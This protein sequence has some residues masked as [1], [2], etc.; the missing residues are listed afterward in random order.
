MKHNN[1][2]LKRTRKIYRGWKLFPYYTHHTLHNKVCQ[3]PDSVIMIELIP[4]Q[5]LALNSPSVRHL[6]VVC[7]F[8]YGHFNYKCIWPCH[9]YCL[10]FRKFNNF[11]NERRLKLTIMLHENNVFY[12]YLHLNVNKNV[13]FN[14]K[15]K[16]LFLSLPQAFLLCF[17]LCN[18]FISFHL[19]WLRSHLSITLRRSWRE[20]QRVWASWKQTRGDVN[21]PTSIIR[22]LVNM[23]EASST[24][25]SGYEV[26]NGTR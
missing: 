2:L 12:L 21:P 20:K 18:S 24:T 26:L 3:A 5:H 10:Y 25:Q 14:I 17:Y 16:S 1:A 8:L 23:H 4:S 11:S 22:P 13:F 15:S 9:F 19:K 7:L 6:F